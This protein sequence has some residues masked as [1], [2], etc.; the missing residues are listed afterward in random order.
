MK[1]SSK[2]YHYLTKKG[3]R[4]KKREELTRLF[5]FEEQTDREQIQNVIGEIPSPRGVSWSWYIKHRLR[6]LEEGIGVYTTRCYARMRLDKHI[7]WHRAIDLL[8]SRLVNHKPAIIYIG[9]GGSTPANSPIRIKKHVRCPG[10]RKLIEAFKKRGNC[11]IR[12]VDE[13]L[14]SQTCALCFGRFDRRTRPYRFKLC[15]DCQPS[16]LIF[17]PETIVTNV[18]KRVLQMRREIERKWREMR[19]AGNQIAAILTQSNTRR[20]VSKKQ[21]FQK[22]WQPNANVSGGGRLRKTVWH[23]DICA[24]KLILYR[25]KRRSLNEN[26]NGNLFSVLFLIF[27]RSLRAEQLSDSS[28]FVETSAS[29]QSRKSKLRQLSSMKMHHQ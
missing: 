26:K 5:T 8:A 15:A 13:Y 16:P 14:T 25:G 11:I 12:M 10:T 28:G 1:T 27:C 4:D 21:R 23:R 3:I 18:G 29:K 9:S 6:M 19:N 7:E 24:A 22:T 2:H 20:L 17:W